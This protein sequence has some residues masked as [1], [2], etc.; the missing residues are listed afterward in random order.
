MNKTKIIQSVMGKKLSEYGFQYVREEPKI[1]TFRRS[2]SGYKSYYDP[3]KTL[4]TQEIIIQDY[5]YEDKIS[6]TLWTDA[7]MVGHGERLKHLSELKGFHHD[8]CVLYEDEDSFH[9]II[10]QI[11]DL[12]VKYGIDQL[13]E[14]SVEESVIVTKAMEIQLWKEHKSLEDAFIK[15]YNMIVTPISINDIDTFWNRCLEILAQTYKT[16][17]EECKELILM[18]TAYLEQ[19]YCDVVGAKCS[20]DERKQI[21]GVFVHSKYGIIEVLPNVVSIWK[22]RGNWDGL[23]CI[24]DDMK[25]ELSSKK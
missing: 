1:W 9:E 7:A 21:G 12:L 18:I 6:V 4:V 19:R 16:D 20:I 14:K 5:N 25:K 15:K 17:Y 10:T 24:R 22:N 2:V 23:N 3:E 8:H 13:N 11:T